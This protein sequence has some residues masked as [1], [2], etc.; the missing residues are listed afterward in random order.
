MPELRK[1]KSAELSSRNS[2]RMAVVLARVE[3][4]QDT[5]WQIDRINPIATR[6]LDQRFLRLTPVL[7]YD[8][9]GSLRNGNCTAFPDEA[10]L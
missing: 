4:C 7:R 3:L 1:K 6:P 5:V 9:I 8:R 10:A 2:S